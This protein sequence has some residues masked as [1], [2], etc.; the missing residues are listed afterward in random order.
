MINR[1]QFFGRSAVGIGVAVVL[2]ET[3]LIT[4]Y[5]EML[6]RAGLSCR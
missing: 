3:I 6:T 5:Q 4:S 1:R 2:N